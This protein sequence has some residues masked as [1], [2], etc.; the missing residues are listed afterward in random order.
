MINSS[1][2]CHGLSPNV[3]AANTTKLC[4]NRFYQMLR[5]DCKSV[6]AC[7]RFRLPCSQCVSRWQLTSIFLLLDSNCGTLI[8]FYSWDAVAFDVI[9][10]LWCLHWTN[11]VTEHWVSPRAKN[12]MF[13]CF[14][15]TFLGCRILSALECFLIV[16]QR[17]RIRWC[18][19][20]QCQHI[21]YPP[22]KV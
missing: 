6:A 2:F 14:N 3:F 16:T 1:T 8:Y 22:T 5:C 4:G 21:N 12:T 20:P 19:L 13:L 18:F 9:S 17:L 10:S 11:T 15:I 7:L